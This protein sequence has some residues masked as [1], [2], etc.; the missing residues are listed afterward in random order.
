MKI[1]Y[2]VDLENVLKNMNEVKK[3]R[4]TPEFIYETLKQ[5]MN[6]HV[7]DAPYSVYEGSLRNKSVQE[8]CKQLN[9]LKKEYTFQEDFQVKYSE[10]KV[11]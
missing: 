11:K 5:I 3:Q 4:N 1:D 9:R 8:V 10:K 2:F 7:D 6:A